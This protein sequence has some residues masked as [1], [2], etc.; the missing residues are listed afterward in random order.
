MDVEATVTEAMG[1]YSNQSMVNESSFGCDPESYLENGT[2][3]KCA[4]NF[5]LDNNTCI[6]MDLA[7]IHFEYVLSIVVP[8]IFGVIV[9]CGLIGNM[10]VIIVVLENKQMRNTTNLLIINLALADLVF[11]IICVP[12]TAFVYASPNWSLGLVWCKIYQ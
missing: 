3:L 2:C 6:K 5:Y 11:I 9:V 10:L 1:L 7:L 8:V 12:F 4:T